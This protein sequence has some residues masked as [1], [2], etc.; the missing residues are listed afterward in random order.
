M[1]DGFVMEEATFNEVKEA[2]KKAV[3]L[4]WKV[5]GLKDNNYSKEYDEACT[6]A[7]EFVAKLIFPPNTAELVD[8][9]PGAKNCPFHIMRLKALRG[10]CLFH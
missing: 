9:N 6:F 5:L 8:Y 3:S 2:T 10:E 1:G 7:A 4:H